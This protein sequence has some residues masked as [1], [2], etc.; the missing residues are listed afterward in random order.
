M[1]VTL[2]EITKLLEKH[3]PLTLAD[4]W[5]NSGLQL[6]HPLAPISHILIG[7]DMSETML[8]YA[9]N[10]KV[11][12]IITH[13]PFFFTGMKCINLDSSQGRI[14]Q[15]LIQGGINLYS[16]HTNLDRAEKGLNQMLAEVLELQ[17]IQLLDHSMT[18]ELYKLV[19]YV[20]PEH[21]E[22][23]REAICQAGAGAIGKYSDC[24]FRS[25]GKGCFRPLNG[26]RPFLGETGKLEV[27][28]ELRLETVVPVEK[29]NLVVSNM[30]MAHPYEEVAYDIYRLFNGGKS[31]SYGRMG[32]LPELVR[33]EEFCNT[34]KR[35]YSLNRLQ[36]VGDL[37]RRVRKIAVVGGSGSSFIKTA[38][39]QNCDVLLTGDLKY[40][41]ALAAEADGL[42]VVDAGHEGT[43]RLVV[44]YLRKFLQEELIRSDYSTAVSAFHRERECI[45]II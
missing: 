3:F 24:C 41:E 17:N 16:M 23:V 29:L 6:G 15:G 25:P 31:Y 18:D 21:E 9:M 20:P 40:H 39:A 43:E 5:D 35:A 45:Q 34:V 1:E 8:R 36:V 12:L 42:A 4:D 37:N 38:M 10:N 22:L 2:R 19:V 7:L 30:L 32:M 27:V 44:D 13:H 26:S 33:L 14:I 11:D 28:E